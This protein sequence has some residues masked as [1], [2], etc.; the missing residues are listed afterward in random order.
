MIYPNSENRVV[1]KYAEFSYNFS[2]M[3]F[4]IV[5]PAVIETGFQLGE[6]MHH[7]S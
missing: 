5:F 3:Y 1:E 6:D 4:N 2:S 7:T